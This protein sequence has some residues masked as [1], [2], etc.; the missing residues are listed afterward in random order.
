MQKIDNFLW[1][2]S[3]LRLLPTDRRKA[4]RDVLIAILGV[5]LF[6]V[7]VDAVVF[8]Q[9]LSQAYVDFS[10]APLWPRTAVVS[11]IAALEEFKYRLLAMTAMAAAAKLAL[12]RLSPAA[13][14]TI[15]VA[16]QFINV[17]PLVLAD[18]LYASLRYWLVGSVWGW[19]YW[20]HG[21]LAALAGHASVHVLL[22]PMLALALTQSAA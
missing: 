4:V 18:P 3:G 6:V 15:I 16:A 13:A 7:T 10:T 20:R 12:P 14:V 21:W 8:R 22:D 2:H 5:S 17:G 19:L 11:A 9:H 1:A